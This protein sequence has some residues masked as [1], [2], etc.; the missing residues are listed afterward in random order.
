M[1]ASTATCS[2]CRAEVVGERYHLG[3]SDMD[4]LYCSSC[5]SV[6][7]VKDR[8]IAW[9]SLNAA[10]P[11]FQP[12][13]RHLLPIFRSI[14]SRFKPCKCGGVYRYMNPPR[15]PAC[16]G[17]F[18]GDAYQDKPVLKLTDGYVFVTTESV[19]GGD[20]SREDVA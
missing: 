8:G 4:A 16:S 14:E 19:E 18:R 13:C 3:F 6:L 1:T 20:W 5:S 17:L 10:D 7:L 15:C 11:G 9:P 2:S 12:Y